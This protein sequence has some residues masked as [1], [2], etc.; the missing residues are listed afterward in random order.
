MQLRKPHRRSG[1]RLC[2]LSSHRLQP[3]QNSS[4]FAWY[5]ALINGWTADR[6]ACVLMYS[7]GKQGGKQGG[8]SIGRQ[9]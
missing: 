9:L 6:T 2:I 1:L 4:A 7:D 8:R 5:T 3:K